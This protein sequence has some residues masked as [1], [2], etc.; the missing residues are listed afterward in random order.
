MRSMRVF[1]MLNPELAIKAAENYRSLRQRGITVR[2]TV[3]TIIATFCIE[4]DLPL[5]F[6]DRDFLPFCQHLGLRGI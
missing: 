1:S 4:H 2:K 5:L 3:D 6:S